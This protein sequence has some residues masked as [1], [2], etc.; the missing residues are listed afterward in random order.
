MED[1]DEVLDAT[2]LDHRLVG[3]LD[4]VIG[5]QVDDRVRAPVHVHGQPEHAV[6]G[7]VEVFEACGFTLL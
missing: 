7:S 6:L 5:V 4:A 3:L 1:R 2:F